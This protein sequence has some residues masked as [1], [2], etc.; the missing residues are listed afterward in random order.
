MK[1]FLIGAAASAALLVAAGCAGEQVRAIEPKLELREAA[2]HLADAQQAGF[3]LTLAGSADDLLAG[4]ELQSAK[5]KTATKDGDAPDEATLRKLL[6]SSFTVAYDKGGAGDEDDRSSL[7]ATVDGVT[8]TEL[9]FA[10]QLLYAKVPVAEIATHFGAGGEITE[11]RQA[12]TEGAPEMADLFDGKWVSIDPAEATELTPGMGRT[13]GQLTD[14]A[15]ADLQAGAT[16]LL[17]GADVKRDAGDDSHIVVTSS[18]TKAYAEVKR[19]LTAV[20]P[21]LGAGVADELGKE[22]ADKP[23]V[24]DLWVEDGKFTAAEVNLLQFIDGA[25]GR[26]ALR[27]D[28]TTGAA[29]DVPQGASKLDLKKLSESAAFA[30]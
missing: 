23:I 12:I 24:V 7:A 9:R 16:N 19:I 14:K 20:E 18:T 1:R 26:A 21:Q 22:P 27:I 10:D 8:G 17:E 25:A 6:N 11:L 15:R 30:E 2:Q 3:T 28:V 29:I 13:D 5:D 4:I